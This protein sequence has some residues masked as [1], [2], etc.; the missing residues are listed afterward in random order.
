[1]EVVTFPANFFPIRGHA[2]VER[3]Q[4]EQNSTQ[5][6]SKMI[7]SA[8]RR[9]GEIDARWMGLLGIG[10]PLPPYGDLLRALQDWPNELRP[11][12]VGAA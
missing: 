2:P 10:V 9:P 5:S 4:R 8:R 1:M 12:C 6:R 7:N 3:G 11:I